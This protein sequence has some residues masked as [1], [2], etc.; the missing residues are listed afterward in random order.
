MTEVDFNYKGTTINIQCSENDLLNNICKKFSEKTGTDLN[1]LYFLYSSNLIDDKLTFTECANLED[2]RR[3]KMNVLVKEK[4]ENNL[5]LNESI[6]KSKDIICPKC[7]DIAKIC[8]KDYKIKLKCRNNHISN[9]ILI[10]EYENSQKMDQS[11]II[12]NNCKI[13][14]KSNTY[15]NE[16]FKCNSCNINL[17]PLCKSIHNKEHYIINYDQKNY[18]CNIHNENY[19]S[20]CKT[21]KINICMLCESL[22]KDHQI[23][24]FGKILPNIDDL[25]NK[26]NEFRKIIDRFNEDIQNIIKQFNKVKDN[27]EIFYNI[28][29]DI[30]NNIDI[31]N[32]NYELIS[33]LT[34]I[35]NNNII[36]DLEKIVN[37][38]NINYKINNILDIYQKMTNKGDIDQIRIIYKNN[39]NVEKIKIFG[40]NFVENNKDKCSF[41]FKGEEYNLQEYLDIKNYNQ[42]KIEIILKGIKKITNMNGIFDKCSLLLS[43]PDISEW[44]TSNITNMYQIFDSCTS[45]TE[46]PDISNWDTSKVANM[47]LMFYGCSS[48]KSLPD[49]SKWNTSNV[50]DMHQ[51]FDG[52]SS[53][54]SLPDISKWDISNVTNISWMFCQCK[55]LN[56][57]PNISIWNS[58]NVVDFEAVFDGCKENLN[59][60]KKFKK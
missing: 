52:C 40:F 12:C 14:N 45:L 22:H 44:N 17:C 58:I 10:D 2:R 32:R 7:F 6:I 39:K 13:K 50:F 9:Y 42:D 30:I 25:K 49:I 55:S 48:L 57:L 34:K 8:I 28:N 24:Y 31:K 60:P 53:L 33:N 37:E 41:M 27:L 35:Y 29:N 16:L 19:I 23:L 3:K 26:N 11:K 47:S 15:K 36:K 46:L 21:C 18:L 38:N 54:L 56:S 20:Y 51:M 4:N 43:L 59:I 1:T 5:N